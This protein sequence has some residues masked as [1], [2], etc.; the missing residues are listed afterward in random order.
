MPIVA[1]L[2]V[3]SVVVGNLAALVQPHLKRMLAYS[4]I[5]QAGYLLC[6]IVAWE[7]TGVPALVYALVVY[8]AMTLG[9]FAYV[10]VIERELGRDAT[11][12]DLAGRGWIGE[13]KTMLHALPAL[14]MAIC[15]LSLAG[16]PPTA[17]FFSKF[18]LF[19]GVVQSG[20]GWLAVVGAV[21]SVISLAYYLRVLV[22]LY[23]RAPDASRVAAETAH[24][25]APTNGPTRPAG[26]RMPVAAA[27]GVVLAA[28]TL[29]LAFVPERIFDAGCDARSELVTTGSCTQVEAA[30]DSREDAAGGT[31]TAAA[32][33]APTAAE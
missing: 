24:L 1:G 21:G 30:A 25:P 23:M 33:P 4:S 31:A 12:A 7:T 2:S 8:S 14:G 16:I 27:L 28:I 11:Y 22:E 20:Y 13:D 6:G 18:G 17:G 9:A 19:D 10:I 32:A 5:A 3:A 29:L 26:T 15:M